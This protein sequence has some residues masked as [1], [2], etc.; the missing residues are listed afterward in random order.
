MGHSGGDAGYRSF[1]L[2]LPDHHLGVALL[3][4]SG[5]MDVGGLAH[6]AAE[7]Y[8]YPALAAQPERSRPTTNT[9]AYRLDPALL[10]RYV[11]KYSGQSGRIISLVREGDQLKGDPIAGRTQALVPTG[12]HQFTLAESGGR[13]TFDG[14]EN[15][16]AARYTLNLDGETR[17]YGWVQPS[18]QV[19]PPLEEYS[20]TYH[21][22]ELDLNYTLRVKD[23][24]LIVQHRRH[25][26]IPLRLVSRDHFTDPDFGALRFERDP[27]GKITALFVTTGRVRNLRFV[28]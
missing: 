27:A 4:N 12:P 13:V 15:G 25:G 6:L 24:G 21:S 11:G 3:S 16:K 9:P 2:W 14:A 5:S 1:L 26:E 19:T 20:G 28:R 23:G 17:A 8:L 10:D 7:A 22:E 18:E